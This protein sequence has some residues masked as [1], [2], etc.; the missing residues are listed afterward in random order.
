MLEATIGWIRRH[1]EDNALELFVSFVI[2]TIGFITM[3]INRWVRKRKYTYWKKETLNLGIYTREWE[4]TEDDLC[5]ELFDDN[6]R[7][8]AE[9]KALKR[10]YKHLNILL[11]GSIIFFM[12]T[13]Y[14]RERVLTA[15]GWVKRQVGKEQDKE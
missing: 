1:A 8:T 14:A 7:L 6:E 5:I 3:V 12:L 10:Q 11:I 13:V 2:A 15:T 4:K 9:N